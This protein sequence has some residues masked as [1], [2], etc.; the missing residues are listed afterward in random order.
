MGL[1][2]ELGEVSGGIAD[3][4]ADLKQN[5]G[6]LIQEG[7]DWATAGQMQFD[8]V[9]VL[10]HPHGE[11]EPFQDHRGRLGV[12]QFGVPQDFRSQGVVQHIGGAGKEQP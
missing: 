11:F 1:E 10:D 3:G 5:F 8:A 9:F 6:D 12:G 4:L 7:L 2:L